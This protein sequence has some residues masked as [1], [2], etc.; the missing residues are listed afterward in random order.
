MLRGNTENKGSYS[1][2][3]SGR[4][5]VSSLRNPAWVCFTWFGM[6]FGIAILAIPAEFTAPVM[7]RPAALDVARVVFTWL[8]KAELVMLILLLIVVRASGQTRR[9]WAMCA[10]LSLIVI[11]QS[12]WL[13]PELAGRA[14]EIVAGREPPPSIAHA[15]NSTLE[16]I[17][18]GS[19]LW[20]GFGALAASR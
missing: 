3:F 17:K 7:T 16:L 2:Q 19:L 13:L 12:A 10:L 4:D 9:W 14:Q 1:V 20:L 8:N 11:A 6:T 18:L 15:V 5:L